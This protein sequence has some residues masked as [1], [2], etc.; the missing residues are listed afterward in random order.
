[1]CYGAFSISDEAGW[2][3]KR[4]AGLWWRWVLRCL[5]CAGTSGSAA[6]RA[7]SAAA[8]VGAGGSS[9]LLTI[10]RSGTLRAPSVVAACPGGE[11]S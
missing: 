1:M 10:I 8:R 3:H 5:R 9:G 6:R 11:W 4:L 7:H 2:D